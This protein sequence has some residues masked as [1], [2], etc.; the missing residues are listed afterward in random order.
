VTVRGV[1]F[2]PFGT[3]VPAPNESELAAEVARVLSAS[4]YEFAQAWQA[5]NMRRELGG[6]GTV[7]DDL[8]DVLQSLHAFT[9]LDQRRDAIDLVYGFW[10]RA[11]EARTDALEGLSR[12]RARGIAL[13]VAANGTPLVKRLW[14]ESA[15][16]SF[17]DRAAF[18]CDF[19]VRLPDARIFAFAAER[20]GLAPRECALVLAPGGP[21]EVP[22]GWRET[23]EFGGF[24]E[25]ERRLEALEEDS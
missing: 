12:L 18:S 9:H 5:A 15:L 4:P 2:E 24:V 25:L 6:G 13:A 8:N 17:V 7:E 3:L 19:G 11:L 20:L 1:V 14:A 16:A 23:F 22:N 21:R 10:R